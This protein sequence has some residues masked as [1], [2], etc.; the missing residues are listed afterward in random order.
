MKRAAKLN[1]HSTKSTGPVIGMVEWFRPGEYER[2]ESVLADLRA[3]QVHELRTGIQWPDWYASG[4]DGWFAWL[5]PRLAREVNILPCFLYTPAPLG[6]APK[7]SS[8]P[9]TP[10]AYAD[11]IDV[12]ITQFGQYFEWVELWNQPNNADSWDRRIDPEWKTFCEMIGGAAYWARQRGKKTVLPG[13]WPIDLDFLDLMHARGVLRY[14]DAVGLHG[15][16]GA[17][18]FPWRGWDT[19]AGEVRAA[20]EKLGSRAELWITQAGFSTWRGEECAQVRAFADAVEAPAERLYWQSVRDRAPVNGSADSTHSDEREYHYGMKRAGGAPKL[21]FQLW[22]EGGLERV[23]GEARGASRGRNG[24]ARRGHVLVTGGAGFIG[25][26]LSNRLL[27]AGRNVLIY[28][29]LSRHGSERNVRWLREAHGERLQVEIA[30]VRNRDAL[31]AALRSAEQVF[32]FAAQVAVTTSLTDPLHDFEVN[33]GGTLN[34]LEEIRRRDNPPPVLFTSTNKVYGALDDLA[35]EGAGS[36][37]QPLCAALRTGIDETRPLDFH[38]PY[39]CSKGAA[40]QY[41]LDYAR[42]FGVPA[43]VFRMSCIYGTRQSGNEDQGWVAHFLIRAIEDKPLTIFGDGMQV[44]DILFADDLVDAF[45]LAQANIHTLSGQAF[46]IGG[47]LGNTISLIELL[48][49]I[50][51]LRGRKPAL[52]FQPWRPGDQRYYVS[53][54]RKFKAATGWAP[55]VSAREG[56]ERLYQWLL[57]S[58]GLPAPAE[59]AWKEGFHAVLTH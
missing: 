8:P 17:V 53:D 42:T 49:V 16:A 11:F 36:R 35:L 45:L 4:G 54:T 7:F 30:D 12:M 1:G 44:R 15:Y 58:R 41:V 26:N 43:V 48:D 23:R 39:G 38:S 57:E 14:I 47:G 2:V 5:L 10:K 20:L 32:H 56:I 21:L 13:T 24:S 51:R 40:D 19:E 31:R 34:L 28:D 33:V 59:L 9:Q 25:A 22:S 37:Y 55:K 6:V 46:N 27:S 18:E 29:D 3:L 52:A 50:E